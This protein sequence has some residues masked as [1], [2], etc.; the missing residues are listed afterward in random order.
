M[1]KPVLLFLIALLA[2]L[3]LAAKPLAATIVSDWWS[4]GPG[5]AVMT[6]GTVELHGTVGQG[7]V[8]EVSLDPARLCSGFRCLGP[9]FDFWLYLPAVRK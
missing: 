2:L 7:V 6:Q 4:I 9:F 1:K 5:S 8:G 3:T